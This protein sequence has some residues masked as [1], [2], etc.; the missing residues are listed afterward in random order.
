MTSTASVTSPTLGA[1]LRRGRVWALLLALVA[2]GTLLLTVAT[3]APTP[4]PDLDLDSAAP[5][6]AR[7]VAQVLREQGVEVVR[8]DD[9]D[10]AL[11]AVGEDTTLLIDDPSS[12]LDESQ[13]AGL[14]GAAGA[15]VLV[16]PTGAALDA[17]LPQAAFAGAPLEDGSLAARCSLP[18]A[19]RAESIPS[20]EGTTYRILDGDAVGC[21]PT[22]DDAYAL[23]TGAGPGGEPVTAIGDADLLRNGTIDE[24][25]RAALALGLLGGEDRLVWYRAGLE[26]LAGSSAVDPADLAPGWVTPALVLLVCVFVASAVWRGRR[27]GPLAVEPLPVVVHASETARGRARLY[28]RGDTRL[29]ALDALR[30]GTLQRAGASLGL[31]PSAGVDEIVSVASELL[32]RDQ[33]ALRRLLVDDLPGDDASLVA[34]SDELLRFESAVRTALVPSTT[35]PDRRPEGPHR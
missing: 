29:R 9:L 32:G 31:S 26:D 7:A 11:D 35:H 27:F 14:G 8:A 18:A 25:G 30:I 24:E 16:Q 2:V 21:F 23:V 28:A 19:E 34:A 4:A 12:V 3:G 15:L 13:Y 33:A 22:G 1:L 5:D 17:L 20:G 10:T 6:G